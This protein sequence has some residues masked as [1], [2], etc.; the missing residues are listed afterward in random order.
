MDKEKYYSD[1]LNDN[2]SVRTLYI[3]PNKIDRVLITEFFDEVTK[4]DGDV[5]YFD[6]LLES[7][8]DDIPWNL[9]E[10]ELNVATV[11]N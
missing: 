11:E 9:L 10:E 1:L 4:S 8:R 6:S 3:N 2:V 7:E 5:L